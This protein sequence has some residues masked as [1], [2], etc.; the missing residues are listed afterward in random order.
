M[1]SLTEPNT[2]PQGQQREQER[3]TERY[4]ESSAV[5]EVR[6][7][8]GERTTELCLQQGSF[9]NLVKEL[10]ERRHIVPSSKLP[11]PQFRFPLLLIPEGG[12]QFPGRPDQPPDN[13]VEAELWEQQEDQSHG[14]REE[15]LAD[16]NRIVREVV[17]SRYLGGYYGGV[18]E[19]SSWQAFVSACVLHDPP[20]TSLLQF[21]RYADPNPYS[22]ALPGAIKPSERKHHVFIAV[23]PIRILRDPHRA[24]LIEARFWQRILKVVEDRCLES[25]G[26]GIGGIVRTL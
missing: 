14:H 9:W 15:W 19:V 21:A 10:R 24:A 25:H 4:L 2:S 18:D 23:P 5:A 3:P 7:L 11:R 17:P 1:E 16:I 12:P 6:R 22:I 26:I 8:R 13:E 20:T